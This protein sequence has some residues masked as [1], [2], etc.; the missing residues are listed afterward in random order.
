M[1]SVSLILQRIMSSLYNMGN[2]T[3]VKEV[4]FFFGGGGGGV[5]NAQRGGGSRS[6]NGG[7]GV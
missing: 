6:R 3:A 5:R 2:L 1:Y 7:G 4:F